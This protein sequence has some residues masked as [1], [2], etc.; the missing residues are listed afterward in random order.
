MNMNRKFA[1]WGTL[2]I[3]TWWSAGVLDFH[4]PK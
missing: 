1:N 3:G 4:N 2:N